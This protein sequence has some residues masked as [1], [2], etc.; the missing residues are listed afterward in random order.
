MSSDT[1][2][3][4]LDWSFVDT[5]NTA[6]RVRSKKWR[7]RGCFKLLSVEAP[8]QND[9]CSAIVLPRVQHA[10]G[11]HPAWK[12]A[13][14]AQN[15]SDGERNHA[16]C[17]SFLRRAGG[18]DGLPYLSMGKRETNR[19]YAITNCRDRTGQVFGVIGCR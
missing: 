13:N 18:H 2:T 15:L 1:R 10:A 16:R 11:K 8:S 5:S 4:G 3:T 17:R 14:A 7:L 6:Q 12:L 9:T 19:L